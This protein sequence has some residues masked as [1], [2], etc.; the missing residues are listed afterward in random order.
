MACSCLGEHS[1]VVLASVPVNRQHDSDERL[2]AC[3]KEEREL[4]GKD[5]LPVVLHGDAVE[6][7]LLHESVELGGPDIVVEVRIGNHVILGTINFWLI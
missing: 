1:E 2:P 7:T 3:P 5:Q 4:P 6:V